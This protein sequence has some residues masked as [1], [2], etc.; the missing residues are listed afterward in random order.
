MAKKFETNDIIDEDKA[1]FEEASKLK[2][3]SEA[4]AR[5]SLRKTSLKGEELRRLRDI[6]S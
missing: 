1:V 5:R 3:M 4:P 6:Y 2:R